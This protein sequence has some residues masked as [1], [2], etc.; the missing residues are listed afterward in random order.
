MTYR[1]LPP[2]GQ[3]SLVQAYI[4]TKTLP[5]TNRQ[6]YRSWPILSLVSFMTLKAS[7]LSNRGVRLGVPP[8]DEVR[9]THSDGVPERVD[10]ARRWGTHPG[11]DY[12]V[13]ISAGTRF[14]RTHGYWVETPSASIARVRQLLYLYHFLFHAKAQSIAKRRSFTASILCF[15]LR[16][17]A[18]AVRPYQLIVFA[19]IFSLSHAKAQS[20]VR[21]FLNVF[22]LVT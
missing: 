7:A 6:W 12:R 1:P 8:A 11:C 14:A 9:W 20:I 5:D 21:V 4:S 15:H 2:V 16:E 22:L 19:S 17:D 10:Y 18:R 13:F 3:R